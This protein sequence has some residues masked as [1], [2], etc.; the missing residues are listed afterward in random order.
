VACTNIRV[1][2]SESIATLTRDKL[3]GIAAFLEKRK[4]KFTGNERTRSAP[5]A[6]LPSVSGRRTR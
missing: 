2:V 6:E 4:P 3:E 1:E 5:A